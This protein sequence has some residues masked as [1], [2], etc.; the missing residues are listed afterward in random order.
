MLRGYQRAWFAKDLFAGL[1]LTAVLIPVGMSYAEA[2]GLPV[3][4]GLYAT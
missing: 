2:S 3:M 1:A 4:A